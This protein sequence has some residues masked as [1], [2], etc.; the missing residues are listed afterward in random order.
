MKQWTRRGTK[1]QKSMSSAYKTRLSTYVDYVDYVDSYSSCCFFFFL[2]VHFEK[3]ETGVLHMEA[4]FHLLR[5]L[6]N[7]LFEQLSSLQRVDSD[8]NH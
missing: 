1:L 8:R 5:Y 6:P 3:L 7:Q 2:T 4:V